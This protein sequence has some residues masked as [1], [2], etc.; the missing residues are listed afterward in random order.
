MTLAMLAVLLLP[1]AA[2]ASV[3]VDVVRAWARRKTEIA[4][5]HPRG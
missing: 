1:S 2:I 4:G 5:R 3:A